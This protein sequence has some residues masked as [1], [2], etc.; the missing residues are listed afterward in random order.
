MITT[1]LQPL[2]CSAAARLNL[3]SCPDILIA[4]CWVT[5]IVSKTSKSTAI[6]FCYFHHSR[7]NFC[8]FVTLKKEQMSN[9]SGSAL[10]NLIFLPEKKSK[11]D[12]WQTDNTYLFICTKIRHRIWKGIKLHV[13][14]CV[15][16]SVC[17]ISAIR[18]SSCFYQPLQKGLL[19]SHLGNSWPQISLIFTHAIKHAQV[20]KKYKQLQHTKAET[21]RE[22]KSVHDLE[23]LGT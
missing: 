9:F 14:V 13:S 23:S 21:K 7:V 8:L 16:V 3:F 20:K 22:K 15:C 18:G 2:V 1:F 4:W 6:S 19:F 17:Y 5:M 11:S 12:V 10:T